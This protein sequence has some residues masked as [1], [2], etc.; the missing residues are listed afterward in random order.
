MLICAA[1]TF[2]A[3][4]IWL[5]ETYGSSIPFWDEWDVQGQKLFRPFLDGSLTLDAVIG[6]HNEHRPAAGRLVWL[7]GLVSAGYWDT[8]WMMLLSVVIRASTFFLL[9]R[10]LA[11]GLSGWRFLLSVALVLAVFLVPFG[12]ENALWGMQS[13]TYLLLFFGVAAN[14]CLARSLVFSSGWIAG[15]LLALASY[16]CMASGAI[17]LLPAILVAVIRLAKGERRSP[18][19]VAGILIHAALVAACLAAIPK[20]EY[21]DNIAAASFAVFWAG[22]L[23]FASWPAPES[24]LAMV[25]LNLP[26]ALVF[27]RLVLAKPS[28][29]GALWGPVMTALWVQANI[30]I[31]AY[32]RGGSSDVASRHT[33]MLALGIAINLALSV[34]LLD[35]L[36]GWP[37]W[38]VGAVIAC[39]LGIT[40]QVL[41]EKAVVMV[42]DGLAW[43]MGTVMVQKQKLADFLATNDVQALKG[44]SH[45]TIPYPDPD[46]LAADLRDPYLRSILPAALTGQVPQSHLS[47][48][49]F[50]RAVYRSVA[51]I[52]GMLLRNALP[53]IWVCGALLLLSAAASLVADWRE[54]RGRKV[55]ATPSSGDSSAPHGA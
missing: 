19:D 47:E 45:A 39:W 41:K 35:G 38:G 48:N 34:R 20:L 52:R 21:K 50:A 37:R 7:F 9:A 29:D 23:K 6:T 49:G 12:W 3:V 32:G 36:R 5:V 53:T 25:G 11:A 26:V 8:V 33:D 51:V 15:T 1:A 24:L 18:A 42:P 28:R 17:T 54:A 14:L 55:S 40:G 31:F 2:A 22:L 30:L 4:Q 44:Q 16:F 43:R 10:S 27:L 46:R 13:A